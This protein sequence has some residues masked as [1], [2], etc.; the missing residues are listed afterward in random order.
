MVGLN[1]DS[2]PRPDSPFLPAFVA[3]AGGRP[4]VIEF[5]LGGHVELAPIVAIPPTEI[6]VQGRVTWPDGSPGAGLMVS[7]SGHGETPQ[8]SGT[9][10]RV[11]ADANGAFSFRLA[12]GITYEMRAFP[13][14]DNRRVAD[15][16]VE[17]AA[18]IVADGQPVTL[19]LTRRR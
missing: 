9:H 3:D 16:R 2:G 19:V 14:P 1:I 18:T 7:A 17:A 10:H 11:V 5:P 6:I 15:A 13:D 8:G 12:A 4:D